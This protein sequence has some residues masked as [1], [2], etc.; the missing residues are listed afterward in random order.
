[1]KARSNR[2]SVSLKFEKAEFFQKATGM[3]ERRCQKDKSR[4]F[5]L[6]KENMDSQDGRT[7]CFS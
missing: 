3:S 2:L 6:L 1:M 5:D 7:K 4:T